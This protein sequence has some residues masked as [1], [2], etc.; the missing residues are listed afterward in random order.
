M[1][2]SV[3]ASKAPFTG[4]A[5]RVAHLD[6][7]LGGHALGEPAQ[8]DWELGSRTKKTQ[9]VRDNKRSAAQAKYRLDRG[10]LLPV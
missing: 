5:A 2:L 8:P 7:E 1:G 10:P 9:W 4:E 6:Q 3:K